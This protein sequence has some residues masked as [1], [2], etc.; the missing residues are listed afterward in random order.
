MQTLKC[1]D[2]EMHMQIHLQRLGKN[3]EERQRTS[4]HRT[5]WPKSHRHSDSDFSQKVLDFSPKMSYNRCRMETCKCSVT[6]GPSGRG[7]VGDI[8]LDGER[9]HRA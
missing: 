2:H 8:A 1:I 3:A 5:T 7:A 9:N 4:C 6:V